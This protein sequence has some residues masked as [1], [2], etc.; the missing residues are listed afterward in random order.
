MNQDTL[1]KA[2]TINN[3]IELLKDEK[4]AW[5]ATWGADMGISFPG[6]RQHYPISKETYAIVSVAALASINAQIEEQI[7]ELEKL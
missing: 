5:T 1:N 7:L 4:V 3:T 2:I 6:I